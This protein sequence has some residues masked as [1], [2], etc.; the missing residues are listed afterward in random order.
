[1]LLQFSETVSEFVGQCDNEMRE[2]LEQRLDHLREHGNRARMPVSKPLGDGIFELRG[3][4]TRHQARLLYFFLPNR[5]IVF[6]RAFFKKS[7]AVPPS[8]IK[9]AQQIKKLVTSTPGGV[10]GISFEN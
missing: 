1:M 8:E 7:R 4:T 9:K 3:K 10:Y 5:R 2:A 6:A